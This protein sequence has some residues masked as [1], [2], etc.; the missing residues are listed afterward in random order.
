MMLTGTANKIYRAA[1]ARAFGSK[2]VS[3]MANFFGSFV[4]VDFT[5]K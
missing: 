4:G 2:D 3:A 5:N 1:S